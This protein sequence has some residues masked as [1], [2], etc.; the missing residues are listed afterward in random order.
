M[1]EVIV[2]PFHGIKTRVAL[3]FHRNDVEHRDVM[4]Q[5]F[6]EPEQEIEVPFL[7]N[8]HMEE[9]LACMYVRICAAAAIDG[10]RCFERLTEE[11]LQ[12][13]LYVCNAWL[14]LPAAI[15]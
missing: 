11:L 15:V 5:Q 9:K 4:R 2:G 10:D 8:I 12:H 6:V 14:F 13:P 3:C 1:Q 7:L